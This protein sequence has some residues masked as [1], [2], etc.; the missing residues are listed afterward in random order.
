MSNVIWLILFY[1]V[2]LINCYYFEINYVD[3][4][5]YSYLCITNLTKIN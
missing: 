3:I 5:N 1:Y 4:V 2:M